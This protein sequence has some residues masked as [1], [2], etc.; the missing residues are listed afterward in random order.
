MQ[1]S[2]IV[3][4]AV[5]LAL[6]LWAH[7]LYFVCL[8]LA[9]RVSP[10]K[11]L[12]SLPEGDPP[13]VSVI[14]SVYNEEAAL[15][16]KVANVLALDYPA[17]RL[18]LI[19]ASDGSTDRTAE[20]VAG[21]EDARIRLLEYASRRG[22]ALVSND[23]VEAA[24]GEWLLF[25][26]ADT[27]MAPDFLQALL[28]HLFDAGVGVVDGSM[29][30]VN[31]FDS[32]IAEDVGFY[33]RYESALKEAESQLG[34]LSSTFGA[35]TAVRRTVFQ[36]LLPTEDVDFTTPL[37]AVKEGYRVV[38]EPTARVYEV[39]HGDART[40]Y[41]ARVRMVTKN[42]PGTLRKID[43]RLLRRPLVLVALISHKLLRWAT[44]VLLLAAL[45][46][47]IALAVQGR[48]VWLLL[49]Q[50]LVYLAMLVGGV[51][52]LSG[53]RVPIAS[54]AFSFAV[55]NAGFLIG[56]VNSI[57]RVPITFYEPQHYANPATGDRHD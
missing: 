21:A 49:A 32:A 39:T 1:S 15:P 30:C 55:A 44:P 3:A 34:W 33:W 48:L 8:R 29:I 2:L 10:T 46:L 51:A 17:D 56:I 45:A 57:R 7:A 50:L 11:P 36:P 38:H 9:M 41:R 23:A 22:R 54:A 25:T 20:I 31:R 19:V 47:N 16:D 52:E 14:L 24:H 35:C 26:D 37:D 28:P 43:R 5:V 13:F 40:Q 53:R 42:L 6:V 18:E 12:P 4:L 27:K